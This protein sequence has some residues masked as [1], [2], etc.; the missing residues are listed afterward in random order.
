FRFHVPPG[1]SGV[2]TATPVVSDGV[3]YLQDMRSNVYALDLKSG[4]LLWRRLFAAANP[5][6]NGL[7][8]DGGRVYSAT[9]ASAF[10]LDAATGRP[11]RRRLRG[12]RPLHGFARRARRE[13]RQARLVRPGHAPRRPRLRLP[14][15]AGAR[16]GGRT[17][18]GVRCGQGG[19]RRRLGSR[20]PRAP[21]ADGGG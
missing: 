1:E 6:P 11:V 14:A 3:V 5:G 18:G 19:A 7:A 8:V 21:L 9:D 17:R 20:D 16:N 10:A 2:F 15:A 13:H 4:K 12:R